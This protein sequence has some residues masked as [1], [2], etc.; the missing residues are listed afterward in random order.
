MDKVVGGIDNFLYRH[1]KHTSSYTKRFVCQRVARISDTVME[2]NIFKLAATTSQAL[3]NIF[4]SSPSTLDSA[5]IHDLLNFYELGMERMISYTNSYILAPPDKIPKKKHRLA[6]LRTFSTKSKLSRESKSK[7]KQISNIAT[8]AMRILQSHGIMDETTDYPLAITNLDGTVRR[9]N[10]AEFRAALCKHDE[11]IPA[12][13]TTFPY[14]SSTPDDLCLIIDFLYFLHIPPPSDVETYSDYFSYLWQRVIEKLGVSRGFR[15]IYI[16]IDKPDFLPPPRQLV[17]QSRANKSGIKDHPYTISDTQLIPHNGFQSLLSTK[18]YKADLVKYISFKL[19]SKCILASRSTR[20]SF[21]LD[22]P[23]A[24]RTYTLTEGSIIEYPHNEHGE[25]DYAVWHHAIHSQCR[26]I[27]IFSG[28]T[29]TWVYGLGLC[30]LGWLEGK[31][32]HIQRNE[33]NEYVDIGTLVNAIHSHPKLQ[34]VMYPA[35]SLVALYVLSGC[36]YTSSFFG[37]TK[38]KFLETF[39]DNISF[40]CTYPTVSLVDVADGA[41]IEIYESSWIRLI[42]SVYFSKYSDFFRHK[43]V[44]DVHKLL[45]RFPDTEEAQQFLT[46][47][48]SESARITNDEQWHDF[49]RRV[50]FHASSV[51]KNHGAKRIPTITA[52]RLHLKRSNYVL[53]LAFSSN[54]TASPDLA[55]H[56]LFGW[57]T[58][59][60][61]IHVEWDTLTT[62]VE[63]TTTQ[64]KCT[65]STGCSSGRCSCFKKCSP[66][67]AKCRCKQCKNSHNHGEACFKCTVR[68]TEEEEETESSDN[69]TESEEE[70]IDEVQDEDICSDN[71]LL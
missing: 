40:I 33:A 69:E 10:K 38:Q 18:T 59:G 4:S 56:N 32:V 16:V 50:T 35:C 55:N 65:C 23:S 57:R 62:S 39:M 68:N 49:V 61:D 64:T 21:I 44:S 25:S 27:V 1:K 63:C 48:G 20:V 15:Q 58:S 28:D 12:F 54:L 31:S 34:Q 5:T 29:D 14:S 45:T 46:W 53:K 7:I 24:P 60:T 37:C 8:N 26:N 19:T 41:F 2:K 43:S 6:K 9:T 30:E 67:T 17:H 11:F 42:T 22:T 3:S 70:T 66:C 52:L 36:D 51:T 47:V 13:T 71:E